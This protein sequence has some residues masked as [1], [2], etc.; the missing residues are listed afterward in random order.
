MR[1]LAVKKP[2]FSFFRDIFSELKKVTWPTRRQA[3]YLTAIVVA[4]CLI[5]GIILG[6]IDYGFT[7]LVELLVK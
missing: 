4:A 6:S 7:K 3:A 1:Q 5:V 2:R